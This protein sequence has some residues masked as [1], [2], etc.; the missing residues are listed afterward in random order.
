MEYI[1]KRGVKRCAVD[2]S[3]GERQKK[4]FGGKKGGCFSCPRRKKK[5]DESKSHSA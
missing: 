2:D 5:L 1:K 3:L 4:K